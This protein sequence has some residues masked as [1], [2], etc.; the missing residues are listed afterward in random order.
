MGDIRRIS[1]DL[2]PA[3][4]DHLG[5]REAVREVF[6]TLSETS[7]MEVTLDLDLP[8][9]LLDSTQKLYVFRIVQEAVS[10]IS[11]HSSAQH[12][13]G[14]FWQDNQNL[15]AEIRDDGAWQ[16]ET[17]TPSPAVLAM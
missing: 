4:I 14:K 12:C 7:G 3:A 2:H 5:W 15:C 1:H 13:R 10:N 16:S 6:H 8:G 11:R 9:K 17:N